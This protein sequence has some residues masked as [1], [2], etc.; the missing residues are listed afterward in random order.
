MAES[1]ANIDSLN[2]QV[3]ANAKTAETSLDSLL[4]GLKDVVSELKE[5]TSALRSQTKA[6]KDSQPAVKEVAKETQKLS[7]TTKKAA[8]TIGKL[9]K[10]LGRIAF[11]RA[12]RTA[13]K[14]ISSAIREGLT[15]L[16]TYSQTVGTAFA[17]AVDN[18]RQH[19]MLLKNAF[20]TALRPAIEA[21]IPLIIKL[22]DALSHAADFVAQVTSVLFGKT[23][24]NGRYTKAILGD[25]E[26]SNEQAKELRRTLLGFDEINRLD[27]DTGSGTSQSAGLQFEQADVSDSAK[28][29]AEFIKNI[30][31]DT[32][33]DVLKLIGIAIAAFKT[34]KFL[35][36]LAPVA[37]VIGSIAKFIGGIVAAHPVIAAVVAALAAMAMYG[38]KISEWTESARGKLDDF[39][40]NIETKSEFAN[41]A[42]ETI[43]GVLDT[44][45]DVIGTVS[46]MIYKLVR[47]DFQGALSELVHLVATIV[48]G[49][50]NL[51]VGA[52]NLILIPFNALVNAVAD[53]WVWLWNNGIQPVLNWLV[54]EWKQI[55]EVDFPNLWTNFK[56]LILYGLK[57][58]LDWLNSAL[59]TTEGNINEIIAFINDIL[60]TSIQPVSISIDTTEIDQAIKTLETTKLPDIDQNIEFI[61]KYTKEHEKFKLEVDASGV[62]KAIDDLEKKAQNA[63]NKIGAALNA[64]GAFNEQSAKT[65]T[66]SNVNIR[67]YASG[68]FPTAGSMFIAGEAGPELVANIGNQTGVWNS[69]QLVQGM[70]NAFSAAL[71]ANPQGGGDIYLDGEVIYRNTVRRNNNAVRATGR[72]A[73]LT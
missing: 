16:Y 43:H 5:M 63:I 60:G 19:I 22:V 46:R 10:S 17:P 41:T 59:K 33:L 51:V 27:G 56:L 31:W 47:G 37:K 54:R 24:E 68:G 8:G 18:L 23:D 4:A 21:V 61:P 9:F 42:L 38:D 49:I 35:A 62:N 67:A 64:T 28:G 30:D 48:K 55:F 40:K 65:S 34:A 1:G 72:S 15:N 32:V 71:A 53:G 26:Q 58:I 7:D 29:V 6:S 69:D 2:I 39:F 52:I 44:I 57:A 20:A 3:E 50:V 36:K 25:L 12:I 73:L 66:K 13:I 11:Y 45:L 14:N 70:F